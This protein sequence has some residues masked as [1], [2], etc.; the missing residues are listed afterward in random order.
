MVRSLEPGN[1]QVPASSEPFLNKVSS[2]AR[3]SGDAREVRTPLQEHFA[4]QDW[5]ARARPTVQTMLGTGLS[6][7]GGNG[8]L[9]LEFV[10]KEPQ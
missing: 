6:V 10:V 7:V 1:Q 4:G 2:L 5:R 8:P 9:S 3:N